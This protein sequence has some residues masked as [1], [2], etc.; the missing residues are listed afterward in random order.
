[1]EGGDAVGKREG[2]P[3]ELGIESAAALLQANC[4][5][6]VKVNNLRAAAILP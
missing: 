4:V 6:A 1:L 5:P 2:R 3:Q